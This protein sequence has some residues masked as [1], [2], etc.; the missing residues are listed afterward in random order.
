MNMLKSVNLTSLCRVP[1]DHS[2]T[3]QHLEFG[4]QRRMKYFCRVNIAAMG[5]VELKV[6]G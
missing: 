1:A 4:K 6:P 5:K 2:V 3:S